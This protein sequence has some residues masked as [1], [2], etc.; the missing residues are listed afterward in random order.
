MEEHYVEES[1]IALIKRIGKKLK[2]CKLT[3]G[4]A[5]SC[6]GGWIASILASEP[7][8]SECFIGGIIS[9]SEDIKKKVLGVSA[10]D[11]EEYGVV[12]RPVAEQMAQGAC[13]VL[14][15][16]CAVA[17]TGFAGP[18]GGF[19]G[20]PVGTVWIAVKVQGN[21]ESRCFLFDGDR[22]EIVRQTKSRY[23]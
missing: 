8:S 14:E 4:T 1:E 18:G 22:Q 13:R 9:Y 2:K 19:D 20:S 10:D 23:Y 15:C 21:M 12:S 6:T 17:T 11:L 5:E 7:E 16:S 3:I